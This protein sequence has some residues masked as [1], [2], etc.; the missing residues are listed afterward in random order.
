[1]SGYFQKPLRS[2]FHNTRLQ[3]WQHAHHIDPW[4]LIE[5]GRPHHSQSV[6]GYHCFPSTN[7]NPVIESMGLKSGLN[8]EAPVS[9]GN[10]PVWKQ[11]AGVV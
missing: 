6:L 2:A 1:M 10:L 11:S 7:L 4:Q 5:V 8:L 9:T 3:C